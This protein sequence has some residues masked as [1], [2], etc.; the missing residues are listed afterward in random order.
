MINIFITHTSPFICLSSFPRRWSSSS[1][2]GGWY[3]IWRLP[4]TGSTSPVRAA[5]RCGV[6]RRGTSDPSTVN[7]C[8]TFVKQTQ[9]YA[10]S[11]Y[12]YIQLHI[13]LMDECVACNLVQVP[14]SFV[15]YIPNQKHLVK[16]CLWVLKHDYIIWAWHLNKNA[17]DIVVHKKY[18]QLD[19]VVKWG[20]IGPCLF[21]KR[22]AVIHSL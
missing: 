21:P 2:M 1:L 12:N 4:N 15:V 8:A 13:S 14:C 11:F 10:T 22:R 18:M 20:C 5:V 3:D 6:V 16:F 9:P 19:I 7:R 17:S